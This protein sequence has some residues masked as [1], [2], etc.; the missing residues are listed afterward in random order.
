M[1]V[2]VCI[3]AVYVVR[4]FLSDFT[5]VVKRQL[6][7]KTS[8]Y[9]RVLYKSLS[10]FG[11]Y[12]WH[13][14]TSKIQRTI[15]NYLSRGFID[16]YLSTPISHSPRGRLTVTCTLIMKSWNASLAKCVATCPRFCVWGEEGQCNS[17]NLVRSTFP[18]FSLSISPLIIALSLP[19]Y[20]YSL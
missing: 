15:N 7:T 18:F 9:F 14:F 1:W 16:D 11:G 8:L 10:S 12:I 17:S 6:F 20:S 3:C 5:G 4:S 13:V 19:C 2:C